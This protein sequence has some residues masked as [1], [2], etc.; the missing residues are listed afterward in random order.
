[1]LFVPAE[2]KMLDS[3]HK[4]RVDQDDLET[5]IPS[6]NKIVRIVNGR[7]RGSLAV[8]EELDVD[9]FAAKVRVDEGPLRGQVLNG[10]QYE[11]ICKVDTDYL[12]RLDS[13]GGSNNKR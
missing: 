8:L 13:S 4:L 6:V 3:G 7:G 5:V 10:V 12:D 9:N 2:V 1:V 11:D